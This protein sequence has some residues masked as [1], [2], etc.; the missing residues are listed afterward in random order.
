M[1]AFQ[2]T[3]VFLLHRNQPKTSLAYRL[4]LLYL[5]MHKF[6]LILL[7]ATGCISP[8][9]GNE[10]LPDS[11]YLDRISDKNS[12]LLYYWTE[13]SF[14]Q[15]K[16]I[17]NTGN[18]DIKINRKVTF[19]YKGEK[20]ILYPSFKKMKAKEKILLLHLIL[21]KSDLNPDQLRTISIKDLTVIDA[22]KAYYSYRIN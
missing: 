14:Q 5:I 4:F 21:T 13:E 15:E 1:S 10:T 11:K 9:T 16:S 8:N 7:F 22:E 17:P 3:F 2:W 20:Y 12:D 19:S 6:Y 18:L